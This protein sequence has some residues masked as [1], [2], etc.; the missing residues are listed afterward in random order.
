[1]VWSKLSNSM[2]VFSIV[3]CSLI[4]QNVFI[5]ERCKGPQLAGFETTDAN[6]VIV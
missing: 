5:T 2:S 3:I 4:L 1:M 6:E